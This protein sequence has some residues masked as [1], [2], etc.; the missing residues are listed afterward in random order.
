MK[1]NT[2]NLNRIK[3]NVGLIFA[4]LI[5]LLGFQNCGFNLKELPKATTNNLD[6]I[7]GMN[8]G[9]STKVADCL[10][11]VDKAAVHLDETYSYQIQKPEGVESLPA[12]VKIKTFGTKSKV[13]GSESIT[14]ADGTVSDAISLADLKF[15]NSGS[16]SGEYARRFEVL[17]ADNGQVICATN[18]IHFVLTP[19]CQLSVQST[20]VQVGQY[21]NFNLSTSNVLGTPA[22]TEWYGT[23][24]NNIDT[25]E[26]SV[27]YESTYTTSSNALASGI[28]SFTKF[29]DVKDASG[30]VLCRTN[31]VSLT[32][33]EDNF[34]DNTG[35]GGG[36]NSGGSEGMVGGSESGG[37]SEGM[38][39]G[40]SEGYVGG[41]SDSG[42]L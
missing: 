13:D 39:G 30:N 26:L 40:G 42:G 4:G 34:T 3:R 9:A 24:D 17:D 5:L 22:E 20:D 36:Q 8:V 23:K 21:V 38:V 7:G 29:I 1:N 33:T 28:G 32:V 10:L 37:G 11:S 25:D 31:K 35:E 15:T 19:A 16:E 41:S 6:G 18:T 27:P 2:K 14:D 12:Q